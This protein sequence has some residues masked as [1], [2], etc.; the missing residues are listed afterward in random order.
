MKADKD[1]AKTTTGADSVRARARENAGGNTTETTTGTQ[2]TTGTVDA[3]GNAG[4]KIPLGGVDGGGRA[5]DPLRVPRSRP[6]GA[7]TPAVIR[8]RS[9]HYS[10]REVAAIM[11][12]GE[13]TVRRIEAGGA[14]VAWRHIRAYYKALGLRLEPRATRRGVEIAG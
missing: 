14:G 10:Q 3:G 4:G 9:R 5:T 11:G 7:V 8:W 6:E 2:T 1:A 12:S 13:R